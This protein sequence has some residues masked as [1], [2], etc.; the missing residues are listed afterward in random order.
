MDL[1]H[2]RKPRASAL[3]FSRS[4]FLQEKQWGWQRGALR[5][6]RM[7]H[8]NTGNSKAVP[9]HDGSGM[10]VRLFHGE[11]S[12]SLSAGGAVGAQ[13]D[14]PLADAEVCELISRTLLLPRVPFL[15]P[16]CSHRSPDHALPRMTAYSR[17]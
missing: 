3:F 16:A 12:G 7:S 5:K 15:L 6:L 1:L 13:T 14:S 11:T 4:T 17:S 9:A 10:E 8:M 2:C